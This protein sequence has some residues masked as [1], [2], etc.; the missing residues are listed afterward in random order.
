MAVDGDV[1]LVTSPRVSAAGEVLVFQFNG[2]NWPL[3]SRL[4]APDGFNGD[5]FGSDLALQGNRVAIGA[6][7]HHN[8]TTISEGAV[9]FFEL[10]AGSWS[11]RSKLRPPSELWVEGFGRSVALDGDNLAVG[12]WSSAW[13]AV[14]TF[15][16]LDGSWSYRRMAQSDIHAQASFGA[17]VAM[18]GRHWIA[19]QMLADY[20]DAGD[21]AGA[22]FVSSNTHRVETLVDGGGVVIPEHPAVLHGDAVSLQFTPDAGRVLVAAEGCGGALDGLI[23][24]TAPVTLPCTVTFATAVQNFSLNYAAG[25][26][27]SLIGN[28]RQ[29]VPYLGSGTAVSAVPAAGYRFQQWN[30]GS[31]A[32]PRVDANVTSSLQVTALFANRAPQVSAL[33]ATPSSL[34]EFETATISVIASDAESP[35]LLF[36]FDCHGDGVF[37]LGPQ[38]S[39]AAACSWGAPGNYSVGARAIDGAGAVGSA[40]V[41]VTVANSVP[42]VSAAI[43]ATAVEGVP[44]GIDV[45]AAMPSSAEAIEAYELDCDFNGTDFVPGVVQS[46]PAGLAC[47]FERGGDHVVAVRARDA[48]F[49]Y[50]G[51]V[52]ATV[53]VAPVNDAP[54][55]MP[56]R[57]RYVAPDSGPVIFSSWVSGIRPGPISALDESGQQVSLA[58]IDID[59]PGLFA[60]APLLAHDGSLSFTPA[61]GVT[62][63]S[64]VTYRACDDG[65]AAPPHANCSESA[66]SVIGI[67]TGT[68]LEVAIDNHRNGV[69]ADATIVYAVVVANAGPNPVEAAQLTTA[70]SPSLVATGWMCVQSQSTAICPTPDANTGGLDALVDLDVGQYLHFDVMVT[71]NAG[72]GELV[73]ATATIA[74]PTGMTSLVTGNDNAADQDAVVPVGLFSDNFEDAAVN[75]MTVPGAAE[76]LR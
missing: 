47:N 76:S 69:L 65:P 35:T 59:N 41:Q 1:A 33:E 30:D 22:V 5:H 63:T 51:P 61:A 48:E 13:G 24:S 29:S 43:P 45:S 73:A 19:G 2:T 44:L 55:F 56:G 7:G 28:S 3:R 53:T 34:F 14:L 11:Y 60:I 54:E 17:S 12:G 6:K 67:S 20:P 50:G 31:V 71:V 52:F 74:T 40:S 38:P 21:D 58:L 72:V 26:N 46:S 68:D 37:E 10:V 75:R 16:R 62:G 49:E 57:E 66:Q 32:N 70:M 39:N 4:Q 8:G 15:E 42:V 25:P 27:G 64:V 23:F 18:D 36:A 9:Y